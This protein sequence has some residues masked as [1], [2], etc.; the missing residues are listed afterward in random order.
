MKTTL[1]GFIHMDRVTVR[2]LPGFTFVVV[3]TETNYRLRLVPSGA[4]ESSGIYAYEQDCS[5]V[6]DDCGDPEQA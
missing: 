6:N 1:Y 2:D 4:D 5:L 3:G